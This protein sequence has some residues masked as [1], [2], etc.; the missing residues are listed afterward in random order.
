M[1]KKTVYNHVIIVF[2]QA[3]GQ[4]RQDEKSFYGIDLW[5]STQQALD[6]LRSA[7]LPISIIVPDALNRDYENHIQSCLDGMKVIVADATKL[8]GHPK[9]RTN[10][11]FQSIWVAS[12]RNTRAHA[13]KIGYTSVPH[14]LAAISLL[15][16]KSQEFARVKG[17]P[18]LFQHLPD[19]LPYGFISKDQKC[20]DLLGVFSSESIATAVY[21]GLSVTR[22]PLDI[23]REDPLLIQLDERNDRTLAAL[24]KTKIL[25]SEKQRVLMSLGVGDEKL[26]YKLR[27]AHGYIEYLAPRPELLSQAPSSSSAAYKSELLFAKWPR[28][29]LTEFKIEHAEITKPVGPLVTMCPATSESFQNNLDRFTGVAT[30]DGSGPISSRHIL[31]PDNARVV[32][33]I[34]AELRDIGY[35]VTTPSFSYNGQFL[36]NVVADLPG[37]G[38]FILDP[39]I[40]ER[41]REILLRYPW[42]DPPGPWINELEELFGT[43]FR[44]MS[45]SLSNYS[46]REIQAMIEARF[47]L[48]P[49]KEWW[50][51]R[52][53]VAGIGAQLVIVGSHLDSTAAFDASYNPA[54]DPAPG[55]D[56]NATGIVATLSLARW[57]WNFRNTLRHTVRFCFFNAEEQGR[58]GSKSYAST[59]KNTGAPI[60]AVITMDMCGYNSDAA[61]IYEIHAGYSDPAIRDLSIP[62][63]NKIQSCGVSLG[64]LLP[65]QIYQGLSWPPPGNS[66]RTLYDGAINRSDHASF[67]EQGYPAVVVSEDFFSNLPSEPG[68]D[69]NPNYHRAGDTVIDSAYAADITCAIAHAV[70][71]LAQ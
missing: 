59:M 47:E 6:H 49:W 12:D 58:V 18:E 26:I 67:H 60:K 2:D 24:G 54:T 19:L 28:E 37:K 68:T 52:C 29:L 41:L 22:L 20:W 71:E 66:D 39:E 31:H 45:A 70:K 42:P 23:T 3:I 4:L 35:C 25:L 21:M 61:R 1:N 48:S 62:I 46:R 65:A 50:L 57:L 55:A 36:R 27:A 69:A 13:T 43:S 17:T 15:E 30:L 11:G 10:A 14:L 5:P 64:S 56:D 16:G 53:K 44:E 38:L 9:F 33:A 32:D 51:R 7:K 63:A 34:V 40:I 8:A